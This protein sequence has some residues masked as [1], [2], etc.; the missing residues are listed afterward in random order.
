MKTTV[1][2]KGLEELNKLLKAMP[3]EA[4]NAAEHELKVIVADLQGKAQSLAPVDLGD[5]R[6]SAF[7]EVEN[8]VGTVGFT[9][10]Y[11]M[12][13]HE[14]VEYRHPKGGQA[15]FLEQPFKQ[16]TPKYIKGVGD[17]VRKAVDHK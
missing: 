16:N 5:L 17:A 11:A 14:E 1:N 6:G 12:R 8:M 13:Q 10:P 2:I 15:K 3:K 7:S 9:E 4:A